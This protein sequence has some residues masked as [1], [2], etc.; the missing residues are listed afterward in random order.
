MEIA[1]GLED[2]DGMA[3][4]SEIA[5]ELEQLRND[6]EEE[7]Q[8]PPVILP[9]GI[10]NEA[11]R[12]HNQEAE[13]KGHSSQIV[14]TVHGGSSVDDEGNRVYKQ[15]RVYTIASSRSGRQRSRSLDSQ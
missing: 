2:P 14:S 7:G 4:N 12:M 8:P 15:P 3:T 1:R 10:Y 9:R 6:D 11:A 5:H 13:E